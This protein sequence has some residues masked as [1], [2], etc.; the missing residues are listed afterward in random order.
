MS[1]SAAD[2]RRAA[3]VV[4]VAAFCTLALAGCQSRSRYNREGHSGSTTAST[5]EGVQ[6]VTLLVGDNYRFEPSTVTV[7]EG[8]VRITL[9]HTG[10]GAPHN[11]QLTGFP[12]D[13]VPD[14]NGGQTASTTF[15]TPS[16]GRYTFVCTIHVKQGQ[17]GTL[18][19]LP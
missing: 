7:H 1:T 12:A 11:W 6:A 13:F 16:P 15:Q 14:V 18:I 3:L 5:F 8:K 19:V 10:T 9:R 4:T 2:R 17:T